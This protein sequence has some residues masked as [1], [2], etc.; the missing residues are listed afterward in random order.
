[1]KV[2]ELIE[3]LRGHPAD[4]R[5]VVRGFDETGYDDAE[6]PFL[7]DLAIDRHPSG[8]HSGAH[9]DAREGERAERC[10]CLG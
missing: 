3:A 8:Y 5:V 7:V 6:Q 10:L 4:M 9:E 2:G 1:M